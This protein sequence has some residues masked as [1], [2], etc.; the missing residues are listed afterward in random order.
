MDETLTIRLGSG[1]EIRL[2]KGATLDDVSNAIEH[3]Q[4]RNAIAASAD[5]PL[6]EN[7]RR[8]RNR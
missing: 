2:P 5:E 1:T 6:P 7:V 8:L 3:L 4:R